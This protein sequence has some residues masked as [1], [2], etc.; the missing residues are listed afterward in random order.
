MSSPITSGQVSAN[1]LASAD[2]KARERGALR[3]GGVI[4]SIWR[5][6]GP[7]R[8]VLARSIV[9]KAI[10]A[11]AQAIPVG[12]IVVLIDQLRTGDLDRSD[13]GWSTAVIGVCV[14]VQWAAGYLANRSAW[15]ATFEMYGELRIRGLDHLRRLPMSFHTSRRSGDTATALTSDIAAVETF[16]HEPFQQLVGALT[17]P[18]VVFIVLLFQ[19]VPMALAT[20]ASVVLSIPIFIWANRTFRRLAAVRQ[21]RQA[22]ASSRMVE[23]VN[24]LAVIRAFRVSGER[25]EKFRA[26]MDDYRAVNLELVVR[27]VPAGLGFMAVVMLGVPCVLFFGALWLANGTITAAT[28]VVFAVLVLRVYQP[29]LAAA[30]S[31]E[32]LRIT[33]AS[34]DRLARLFDEPEQPMPSRQAH[35]LSRFDVEFDGVDFEYRDDE[36]TLRGVD[37]DAAQG[38]MTAIVGPSGAGKS[39]ILNLIARFWDV[40]VGAVRIGGVDVRELTSEQ[41]FDAVAVVFQDVYLFPG[42]IEDNIA[43]G[44]PADNVGDLHQRVVDAA[45]AA[46]AHGFITALPDGYATPV[47]E[48]GANLSGGE[49]Q[50]ISVA[51]A[52]LKDAPIVLLDEATAAIDPIN[53]RLIQTA[54]AQ[55]VAGKT[56]II[57]AHRLSTIAS[58]DQILVVDRGS[59]VERGTHEELLA[60]NALYLRLWNQRQRSA[61]WTIAPQNS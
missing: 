19:N 5:L 34:L 53:E 60:N 55:L 27:L 26:A 12:V 24:G 29:L 59:I 46:Q 50:R 17:A 2:A 33:D 57:V 20:I 45:T 9:W 44:L 13:I 28:L 8:G 51:R 56:V 41:L 6:A 10:Q 37:L 22:E 30:D 42:T 61:A 40:N 25:L 16:T 4:T 38:T 11:A 47:G 14:V 36:P 35:D 3:S 48:G 15:I 21:E 32:S 39:T 49:R 31:F 58:A 18:V 43:F 1:D 54:L 52:I 23:Y 7:R